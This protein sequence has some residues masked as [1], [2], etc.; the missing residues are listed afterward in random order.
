MFIKLEKYLYAT[1]YNLSL[2]VHSKPDKTVAR[3]YR[4]S[5]SELM[6]EM[7]DVNEKKI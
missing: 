3:Q 2:V 7:S 6:L 4:E 5:M 1:V